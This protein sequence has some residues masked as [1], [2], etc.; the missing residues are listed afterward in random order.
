[1]ER[2]PGAWTNNAGSACRSAI[3][4][5]VGVQDETPRPHW[6]YR[7]PF[8]GAPGGWQ[9]ATP[10]G[11]ALEEC[12][13]VVYDG[14]RFHHYFFN[15]LRQGSVEWKNGQFSDCKQCFVWPTAECPGQL[16]QLHHS[17]FQGFTENIGTYQIMGEEFD[18][19]SGGQTVNRG[20]VAQ[21]GAVGI[22][23]GWYKVSFKNNSHC[24]AMLG[25]G[26]PRT[27]LLSSMQ[28]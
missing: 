21:D 4:H 3:M 13:S 8:L 18:W 15:W 24:L 5:E 7:H 25:I 26:G 23:V 12:S 2:P 16:Q 20:M 6:P 1:M 10:N 27:I 28:R 9:A 17:T 11:N 19:F 22:S 14:W